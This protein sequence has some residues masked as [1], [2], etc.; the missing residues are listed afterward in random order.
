MSKGKALDKLF[1]E[2]LGKNF[3]GCFNLIRPEVKDL[4]FHSLTSLT[5]QLI[6]IECKNSKK[7]LLRG[8]LE[9]LQD[10]NQF[11]FLGSP[12]FSSIEDVLQNNLS[13]PD[14][15]FHDPM[16]DLLH[17]MK[18]HEI[19]TKDLKVLLNTVNRQKNELIKVNKE[20]HD[21]ALFSTQNPDPLIRINEKGDLIQINP[22]CE[23]LKSFDYLNIRYDAKNLFKVIAKQI[24][25]TSERW[26][27]EAKSGENEYSFVCI[28]MKEEGYINI[29]GRNISQQKSD[30]KQLELLS[31]IIQ[32][33]Q[34]AVIVTNAEGKIEWVNKAFEKIT[35]YSLDEVK[36]KTPGSILQGKET[37]PVSVN[38]IREKIRNAEPFVTEIFNYK[39]SGNGYWLRINGQPIFDKSGNVTGFFA[40][41]EDITMEKR[42]QDKINEA[43]TRMSSLITNL[44]AGILLENENRTIGLINKRF[45]DLFNI[46]LNPEQLIGSDCSQ[47]AEQSKYLFKDP[48]FFVT[49][50]NEILCNRKLVINDLLELKDGCYYERDFV[51]IWNKE[52]YEGHLWIYRDISD[53]INADIKL[54]EQRMFYEE[55]LDNIP[56]DIA[57]FDNQHNYLY[58][59]PMGISDPNLRKWIIGKKDEDYFKYRNKPSDIAENRRTLF[60]SVIKSRKLKS[61]EEE[62]LQP[63]GSRKYVMRNLYPVADKDC[64]IKIVIGYGV[65]ITNIKNIQ[66]QIKD[67]EKKYRDVID[68]SLAMIT[69]HD[70]EGRLITVNPVV[71]KTYGYSNNELIGHLLKEFIPESD[72]KLFD[73]FYLSKIKRDK[74]ARGVLK[75]IHKN[76][77]IVYSLF[78]N[79]L[80]EEPGIEPYVIGFAIDITDRIK[81]EQELKIAKKITDELAQTKQQFLANMSHEIRTPMNAILGMGR[82]LGKT[83]LDENQN[84][85]LK[86]INK[87]AEN[88]LVIINDILD[89]SKIEAGKL[90]LEKIGFELNSI[91]QNVMEV[92]MF[93]AE[94][95]GLVFSNSVYDKNISKVLIGDPYRINQILLN[96]VSNAIKF[97]ENGSV[98]IVCSMLSEN[99]TKQTICITVSDTG[100]G[101]DE[102]FVNNLFEKFSQED[103]S[104]T[105]KYGGTGLGM[106]IC[107]QLVSLMDGR[108]DVK[109]TKGKGTSV[110]FT[111]ELKKGSYGDLK[112]KEIAAFDVNILSGR[113]ILI[114]DDNEMN[115]VVA[116]NILKEYGAVTDEAVNG[117]D[118]IEKLRASNYS[119][120]LMDVQMPVM[121]GI[122]STRIIRKEISKTIPVIALTAYAL[123]GN[124]KKFIDAGMNDY[125]SKPFEENL[126]MNVVAKWLNCKVSNVTEQKPVNNSEKLYDLSTLINLSKG[127]QEF[128]DKMIHLFIEQAKNSIDQISQAYANE[129][130][131]TIKNVAHSIKPTLLNMGILSLLDVV[132]QTEQYAEEYKTSEKLK[133]LID[134]IENVLTVVIYQLKNK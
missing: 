119:L 5:G 103:E 80:K 57:V 105:R 54:E 101:M 82:Q 24:D 131:N 130:F 111:I 46:P 26:V 97:T 120:V 126:L 134:K 133:T 18:A 84:F 41:E 117:E 52:K 92:M 11:L 32:E 8:Q 23:N 114:V 53:K 31:L 68:N 15:A 17:A 60:E 109:S 12:W 51:P 96:F 47:A 42:T 62:L 72:K 93:K 70:L 6:V 39:K 89:I 30:Q 106:N 19:T 40:I 95:K 107:K 2:I 94:E 61:W 125:V 122:Q 21:I 90:T 55:I 37:D 99:E 76:G 128:I 45:C 3:S 74:K 78:N 113:K 34:N 43:A 7:T 108:L 65:D 81:A 22:A 77:N 112:E 66:Q 4:T 69:T 88:L 16:I 110:S 118:A 115:R 71:C 83:R 100:T 102:Q 104:I 59:N 91:I 86:S 36:G 56:S 38:Y 67:S 79:I 10:T 35:E 49:R 63:D 123:K 50:I 75:I 25:T 132:N 124:D 20:I 121:D 9:F 48:D 73:K 85:Y 98:D 129:D 127:N 28:P 1:P 116:A 87:S 29:Y 64:K 44:Q 58:V 27:F 14:F 13:I 33:T